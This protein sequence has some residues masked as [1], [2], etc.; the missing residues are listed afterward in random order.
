MVGRR[1]PFRNRDKQGQWRAVQ[2]SARK[3]RLAATLPPSEPVTIPDQPPP[4]Q[5]AAFGMS[6]S[7]ETAANIAARVRRRAEVLEQSPQPLPLANPGIQDTPTTTSTFTEPAA[8]V[9]GTPTASGE[10]PPIIPPNDRGTPGSPPPNPGLGR[11]A[12]LSAVGGLTAA[13]T[14]ALAGKAAQSAVGGF[15]AQATTLQLS[16]P[17]AIRPTIYPTPPAIEPDKQ[18]KAARAPARPRTKQTARA[19]TKQSAIISRAEVIRQTKALIIVLEEAL[20]YDPI[21]GHNQTPQRLLSSN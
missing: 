3:K 6:G 14:A 16:T 13:H 7:E 15:N 11:G 20:D 10:S 21:R 4:V 1:P 5:P 12:A 19:Q 2:T 8:G 9:P 18:K 17:P